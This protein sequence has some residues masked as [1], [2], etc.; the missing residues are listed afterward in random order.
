[1][2]KKYY[3]DDIVKT[4]DGHI[5]RSPMKFRRVQY[6][7]REWWQD[8]KSTAT[9]VL[10]S[11]RFETIGGVAIHIPDD[12]VQDFVSFMSPRLKAKEM[13]IRA[14]VPAVQKAYEHYQL[15]LKMCG[16]DYDA[17]Y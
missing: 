16:G 7:T 4:F 15:L 8:P 13:E 2:N 12:K 17:G 9:D 1:M 10:N 11:Y 14:N 6:D 3:L 5:E